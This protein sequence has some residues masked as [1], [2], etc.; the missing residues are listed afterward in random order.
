[1]NF[2]YV[3]ILNRPKVQTEFIAELLDTPLLSRYEPLLDMIAGALAPRLRQ[4]LDQKIMG[5]V[6]D[7]GKQAEPLIATDYVTI[8]Q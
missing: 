8:A 2:F 5:R 1:M 6:Q 3:Q 4:Q 7:F